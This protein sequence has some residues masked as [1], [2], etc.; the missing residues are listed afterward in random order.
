MDSENTHILVVDDDPN[1]LDLLVDTLTSIGYHATAVSSGREALDRLGEE[2]FSLMITDIRMPG[3]D[4]IELSDRVRRSHP[5]MPVIF[6]SGYVTPD[7]VGHA[8]PDGFLAKPFRIQH[9]ED[10]IETALGRQTGAAGVPI[11]R[12][13][14]VDDDDAFRDMLSGLLATSGFETHAVVSAAEALD[15]LATGTVDAV[16]TD[17]RMPNMDGIELLKKIKSNNPDMPVIL[18]TGRTPISEISERADT[19]S[20]AGIL[21]KRHRPQGIVD[22]LNRLVSPAE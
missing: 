17:I 16:I 3:I 15:K 19:A 22:L 21:E 12:V 10:M 8:S 14:L 7:I 20:A 5:Q 9:L 13:L 2:S 11:R 18:I 4:G 1:L 6:I